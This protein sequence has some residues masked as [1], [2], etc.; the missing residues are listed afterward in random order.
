MGIFHYKEFNPRL[1]V[2]SW[3]ISSNGLAIYRGLMT[4][5][6]WIVLIGRI[7]QYSYDNSLRI[8][9]YSNDVECYLCYFT[10]LSF[11]G[12]TLYFT[13]AFIHNVIYCRTPEPHEP[14]SFKNQPNFLNWLFWLL[15][16]TI[17]HYHFIVVFVYW[18]LLSRSLIESHPP[19]YIW[20]L[21]ISVHGVDFLA[22]MI[23]LFL[24]RQIMKKSFV[25][26]TCLGTI[27]FMLESFV[28]FERCFGP[29][30][31]RF[32][33]LEKRLTVNGGDPIYSVPH[34]LYRILFCR[35]R[36]ASSSRF[37]RQKAP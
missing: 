16:H 36:S 6:F 23:E 5:Y 17:V 26:L 13:A 31:L 28:V 3:F 32:F 25:F 7:L 33:G 24:N 12:Q 2:T 30:G 37:D 34:W 19:A 8:Y 35:I 18:A 29:L 14:I 27:F 21:A 4:V 11:V 1:S 15:Y 22:M 20:W 9:G 10:N